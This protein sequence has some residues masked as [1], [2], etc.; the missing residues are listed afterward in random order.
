MYHGD[1]IPKY[2]IH[3]CNFSGYTLGTYLKKLKFYNRV[4]L[5]YKHICYF[6]FLFF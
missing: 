6:Y 3:K 5:F 4:D 2:Y 1:K